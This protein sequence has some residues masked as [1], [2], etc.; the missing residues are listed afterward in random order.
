MNLITAIFLIVSALCLGIA[1]GGFI[2]NYQQ[3]KKSA[4][5]E[6]QSHPD[7]LIGVRKDP[8]SG[9][10]EVLVAG[11]TF[12][13]PAEM[14][15]VQRSLAGYVAN[16][17]RMWLS[18]GASTGEP[19]PQPTPVE[20]TPA[21][22]DPTDQAPAPQ[23]VISPIRKPPPVTQAIPA[24]GSREETPETE[25]SQKPKR[26]GVISM[27]SRALRA[28]VST[29]GIGIQSIAAQVNE[30]LQKKIKDTP[31]DE[32]G[33]CLMELPGQDMVV[34]IGLDKYDSVNAVPDEEIR[35]VLQSAV[36]DWLAK[37]MS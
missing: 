3:E 18:P 17:L 9:A 20:S 25:A 6:A 28:D 4:A 16:D 26:S 31:L 36:N 32:R 10:I 15:P 12:H 13:S 29:Q 21:G 1:L 14:N 37:N 35:A 7:D 8:N 34:M 24:I 27:I 11:K 23:Q 2:A 5:R 30:I 19:A 22:A 33:I